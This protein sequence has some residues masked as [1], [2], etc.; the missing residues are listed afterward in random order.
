MVQFINHL[1]ARGA[2]EGDSQWDGRRAR[3]WAAPVTDGILP[4]GDGGQQEGR[5][6]LCGV[7]FCKLAKDAS[8]KLKILT[9]VLSGSLVPGWGCRAGDAV[10]EVPSGYP[11]S[12]RVRG[13]VWISLRD[14]ELCTSPTAQSNTPH[15]HPVLPKA[16]GTR[17]DAATVLGAAG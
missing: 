11:H 4:G 2:G 15:I 1:F 14:A 13:D 9:Q 8:S 17:G 12:G 16:G 3:P 10:H 5:K 6:M 7:A